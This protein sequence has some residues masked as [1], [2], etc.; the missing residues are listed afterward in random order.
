MN[1]PTLERPKVSGCRVVVYELVDGKPGK[2]ESTTVYGASRADVI[3]A[4]E[5][6]FS[7]R[8]KSPTESVPR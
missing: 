3:G 8:K 5:R 7:R 4:L 1:A 2:S 6:T